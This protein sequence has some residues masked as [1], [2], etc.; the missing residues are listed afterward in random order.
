MKLLTINR[1]SKQCLII[2]TLLSL[3]IFTETNC[4]REATVSPEEGYYTCSMHPQVI[5]QEPGDC[6]ICNMKLSFVEA[7]KKKEDHSKHDNQKKEKHQKKKSNFFKFSLAQDLLQNAKIYT[8][9]TKKER[10]TR[11]NSYS[12]HIDYN[13]DPDRLV[14]ISTKYDGWIE[15]LFVSKEGQSIKKGELLMGVYSQKIL[16]SKEEY[17][18]TY[19]SLKNSYLS[20]GKD[21]KGLIKDPTLVASRRKL[22]Y[23]DVPSSQITSLEKSGKADRLTYFRSPIS[24]TLIKKNVL[25]GSFIKSGQELFRIANL[26][27]LWVFI[28]IFEKDLPFVKKGQQVTI[29]T[30]AHPGKNFSGKIDLIYPFLDMKTRDLKVRIVVP[31]TNFILKPGMYANV[32]VKS[33]LPKSVITIP[34]LSIIYSGEENY[35]FVSLGDG[36][37]EVRPIVV[38][39]RS[40]GKAVV[41]SGLS[42]K[43]LVVSNGQFLL[44]SEASLKEALQKGQMTEHQH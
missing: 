27:T 20:Q 33:T 3:F 34:E 39:T 14:I 8:V 44:D 25:Q 38:L 22:I 32:K 12:G 43:E 41:S 24:G 4:T 11:F 31:N 23:L 36:D 26:K 37:F 10:F 29:Q 21:I 16:A 28:H 35:V 7:S 9:P 15:K 17:L 18:T 13:E 42:E 40:D 1:L 6:P 2:L 30:T 19:Q 5:Q